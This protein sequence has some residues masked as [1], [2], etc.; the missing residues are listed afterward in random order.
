MDEQ[1]VESIAEVFR[2]FIC[3]EK[4]RDAR[5]CPHCS[6]L[7][8]FSCIRRWLTEQRAQCPHCRAPLQ[9]RELVNCRWAEEVTQQL[10]TLQLCNLTKHEDNDKDKCENHHEKLSVFCWTCKK[11]IC[12][13]C[14]LWGGMH[15]GHTFKPLVEIYEQH[16]T[17]VKEEVAKLRRRL[18]ELISLVQEVERNVEAVR[19][20]KD[21][22]VREIR[23]AVEMMIA[24][25]DNQLKN[26]L[27]TLMGQKTSLT[28]ETELLESL[29][30]EVEHQ[31]H[32]CSKSELISKSPEILLM[33]QQVHRK[34]MQSF[35]TTPVPPDFTSELVPAYDSSTFV[36]V[37][38]STLRQRADPVYSPPLQICGLCW[39]LKVY[40]D[41]N[42]VVRG[43]YLSV[44]L[45]LSAGLPETSK[46][47]YRVE[48]VH[49]ASSDPSKNI[50]R[51]FASDFEVGEC[52]GYNRFFRLDLLASEGYLNMQ[53]DTLV[54]RYQV[55][56][57]T[58]FQKCRD[59]YW[60]ISQLETAQSGYIQQINNLKERLAIELFRHRSSRSSSPHDLR[61]AS[62]S[63]RDPRAAKS[64]GDIQ[65]TLSKA[66]KGSEDDERTHHDDSNEIS[67]GDLEVECLTEEEVN[68]LDC[69]STSGSSTA[70]SNTEENDIDEETMSGEND[71]D[72][73]GNLDTEEGELPDDLDGASGASSSSLRSSHRSRGASGGGGAIASGVSGSSS[74]L[75][76]DPSILMQLLDMKEH[77]NVESLWGLQPRQPVI[78]HHSQAGMSSRKERERR[79]QVVRRSAPDSE[80]LV[81]LKAQMAEVRSKMS[82]VNSRVLEARASAEPR[83]GPSGVFSAEEVPSHHVDPETARKHAELAQL[84][85]AVRSRPGRPV[86]KSLSVLLEGSSATVGKHP[87][88]EE[89]EKDVRGAETTADVSMHTK[90]AA[91]EGVKGPDGDQV[92]V[93]DQVCSSNTCRTREDVYSLVTSAFLAE[94][95]KCAT[96]TLGVT[97]FRRLDCESESSGTSHQ[98]WLDGLL[99]SQPM[100]GD[101][102]HFSSDPPPSVLVVATTSSES[103][104][105]EEE[106]E[107]EALQGTNSLHYNSQTPPC[108]GESEDMTDR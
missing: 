43:N 17:K 52:W 102:G 75:D 106:E 45:E 37:H 107:E 71:V 30:Q 16:V 93:S 103:E 48:M 95:K 104:T 100:S 84:V 24:R 60:Y 94:S 59:Q 81:R 3:M 99:S 67:D 78:L 83:P 26:K 49:Q 65:T 22:R 31:L 2:C 7:C 89:T 55:R 72:F 11:C 38:F 90:D 86:R 96:R 9:L 87:S 15:G 92:S 63:E 51:E 8:C 68:P 77:N 73:I 88:P 12:H 40:P 36:L 76:M 5:L 98:S 10:D 20:A 44:F 35:V 85:R 50:I 47:E 57:P 70:T 39:R 32:S 13:Q 74:L 29:L 56:S 18:M 66:K 97:S 41:G 21:E 6:K 69:S 61:L 101:E 1:S 33:F 42:G 105:E 79:P 82:D 19:G 54:L 28:Q 25:L 91:D 27:I 23:N 58:F 64:D 53:T 4:L 108:T 14:A 46:Y 62:A 34:P 80:V